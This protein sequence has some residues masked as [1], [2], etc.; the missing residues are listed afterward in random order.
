MPLFG[1]DLLLC[2]GCHQHRGGTI[3]LLSARLGRL[4]EMVA[5]LLGSTE[6]ATPPAEGKAV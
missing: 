5:P 1:Y 2:G 6:T 3:L 4:Q